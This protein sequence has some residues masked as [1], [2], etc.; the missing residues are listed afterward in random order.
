[1]SV[2]EY[3]QERLCLLKL[4]FSSGAILSQPKHRFLTVA[5]LL[6][7]AALCYQAS[8]QIADRKARE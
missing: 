5:V 2:S 6:R 1:M 8:R 3:S 4:C 7:L